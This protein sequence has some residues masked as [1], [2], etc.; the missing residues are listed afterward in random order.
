MIYSVEWT[1]ENDV[2][3]INGSTLP[4]D[5]FDGILP[6]AIFKPLKRTIAKTFCGGLTKVEA[7][8]AEAA[9]AQVV[10]TLYGRKKV[11]LA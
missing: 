10:R 8:N 9:L 2:E 6:E 4:A 3:S 5:Y 11:R 7:P 1:C